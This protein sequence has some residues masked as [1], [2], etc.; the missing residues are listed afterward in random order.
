MLWYKDSCTQVRTGRLPLLLIG[1]K[2]ITTASLE[3]RVHYGKCFIILI[4]P[5]S[6]SKLCRA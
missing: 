3:I 6:A 2:L 4:V 5:A 1:M